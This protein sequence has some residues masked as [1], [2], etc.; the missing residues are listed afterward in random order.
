M[1]LSLVH[2]NTTI[3]VPF[4]SKDH[5][6]LTIGKR[7]QTTP[8][9]EPPQM[10]QDNSL[11]LFFQLKPEHQFLLEKGE[12]YKEIIHNITSQLGTVVSIP[13]KQITP[14][15][16]ENTIECCIRNLILAS[17]LKTTLFTPLNNNHN[18]FQELSLRVYKATL[19]GIEKLGFAEKNEHV[20]FGINNPTN[21]KI[22]SFDPTDSFRELYKDIIDI[23]KAYTSTRNNYIPVEVRTKNKDGIKMNLERKQESKGAIKVGKAI[24]KIN[25]SQE[26]HK[27]SLVLTTNDLWKLPDVDLDFLNKLTSTHLEYRWVVEKRGCLLG[28]TIQDLIEYSN[29]KYTL[30]IDFRRFYRLYT[31]NLMKHGRIYG[32]RAQFI[33]SSLRPF[34]ILNGQQTTELDYGSSLPRILYALNKTTPPENIY[35]LPKGKDERQRKIY[36]TALLFSLNTNSET[37]AIKALS[38][39][40]MYNDKL[41]KYKKALSIPENVKYKDYINKAIS[42]LKD[43]KPL[44]YE[45]AKRII[46]ATKKHNSGIENHFHDKNNYLR[47]MKT[48]G[49]IA[50]RIIKTFSVKGK[51]IIPIHDSFVVQKCDERFLRETMLLSFQEELKTSLLPVVTKES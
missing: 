43:K 8:N 15:N 16:R 32:A 3:G 36:K 5:C 34:L 24:D 49:N 38:N 19:K 39:Q 28:E 4:S 18:L 29:D 44:E 25:S 35:I 30:E 50:M 6:E 33:K 2:S 37:S 31:D 21:N 42:D 1:F 46:Q 47:M 17:E 7:T 48:E 14:E 10:N 40:K 41:K 45:V 9:E 23:T 26:H 22:T 11:D 13:Y 27:T 51:P 20:F 12:P